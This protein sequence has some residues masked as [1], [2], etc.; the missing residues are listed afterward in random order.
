MKLACMRC[1]DIVINGFTGINFWC[2]E[3][4]N[5]GSK[6][7]DASAARK[8]KR[9]KERAHAKNLVEFGIGTARGGAS[10]V[11]GSVIR[12]V[13]LVLLLIVLAHM[14]VPAQFGLYTLAVAFYGIIEVV[15]YFGIGTALRKR[16]PEAK[17][18]A[19]VR[20]AISSGYA[21]S[22]AMGT[23][24]AIA[25]FL[26]SGYLAVEIYHNPAVAD[27][28]EIVSMTLI[29][30][31]L[32]NTGTA[33]LV[34]AMRN[35][36][37]A[38]SNVAYAVSNLI[39]S[40]ALILL[41]YGV[42]GA[43]VGILMAYAVGAMVSLAYLVRSLGFRLVMPKRSTM[44][45]LTHISIPVLVSNMSNI[46]VTSFGIV[47]LGA[48]VSSEILGNYG[49]A[50]KLGSFATVI[51]SS[52]TFVLL[53]AFSHAFSNKSLSRKMSSV[54]NGSVY[55][56][57][58]FLLAAVAYA[59]SVSVPLS[60]L[61]FSYAYTY[62]PFYFA[63]IATGIAIGTVGTYAG[64]LMVSHGSVRRFMAYQVSVALIEIAAMALLVPWLGALGLL[65]S[66]YVIG[67][68]ASDALYAHA[69]SRKFSFS[70][71]IGQLARL[72][73]SAAVL[74]AVL[75]MVSATLKDGV[76][77]IVTNLVIAIVVYPPLL[78]L[79]GAIGRKNLDFVS[80]TGSRIRFIGWL[81]SAL[82]EYADRFVS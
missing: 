25:G 47:F 18:T 7:H 23:I 8:L 27:L 51:I 46:G 58:I 9:G 64:T 69:L 59:I 19:E 55:Y 6:T 4:R 61:L 20:S 10:Y 33:A 17:N 26:A 65:A 78:A 11:V 40:P 50:Y 56:T 34:G 57:L 22:I 37:A 68:V 16:I 67:P 48:Y 75:L 52:L 80:K 74:C 30:D 3:V 42:P 79:F 49:A 63:I 36:H 41:G 60:G 15:G 14:L 72:A 32:F 73:A 66:F 62:A 5:S 54:Y 53:P 35:G 44:R 38:V 76:E 71:N 1:E 45:E 24:L 13:A 31:V 39:F 28:L 12:A 21:Y 70:V 43:L 29:A 77:I 82:V 81:A 2:T